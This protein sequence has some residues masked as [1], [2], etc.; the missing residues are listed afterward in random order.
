[1]SHFYG[2]YNCYEMSQSKKYANVR[3]KAFTAEQ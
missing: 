1:M 3:C 2:K